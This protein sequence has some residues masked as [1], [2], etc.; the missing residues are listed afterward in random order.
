[1]QCAVR[2]RT[3]RAP[4]RRGSA[5]SAIR[6]T[7]HRTGAAAGSAPCAPCPHRAWT[8][9]VSW[10]IASSAALQ[11]AEYGRG[12]SPQPAATRAKQAQHRGHP[13]ANASHCVL[14]RPGCGRR[15]SQ[16]GPRRLRC[17]LCCNGVGASP[18]RNAPNVLL[19]QGHNPALGVCPWAKTAICGDIVQLLHD[20]SRFPHV[21]QV[22]RVLG[23]SR[24][25]HFLEGR[26]RNPDSVGHQSEGQVLGGEERHDSSIDHK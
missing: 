5:S 22:I 8:S 25:T 19:F 4:P 23:H 20:R 11:E 26:L 15:P 12:S 14:P 17:S 10:Q 21:H 6:G 1:M 13:E 2:C 24:R 7:G 9:C 3:A 16:Y 18:S